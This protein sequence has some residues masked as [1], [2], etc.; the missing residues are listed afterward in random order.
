MKSY[1]PVFLAIV[2]L[3]SI[4]IIIPVSA[5][6]DFEGIPFN[7]AA[8][9]EVNGDIFTFGNYGL[10]NPPYQLS[11]E[12]PANPRYARVYTGIWGGTEKY[13]G[14]ADLRIN[15]LKKITYTLYGE[16]DQNRDVYASGHGIYW[17]AYDATDLLKKGNNVI[18]V[19][20]SKGEPGNKLD[21]R[22]YCIFVV[23]AVEG[24]DNEVTRYWIAE[25][26]E[27]LH[28]EGWAGTNP[29]KHEEANVTFTGAAVSGIS[30]ANLSVLL[31]AGGKGQ[32]DYVEFNGK[33][34]GVPAKVVNGISVTDIGDEKSFDATGGTG[35]DSRY[36][37][38]ETFEVKDLVQESDTVRF[39]RGKDLNG[40]GILATTGDEPEAEDYIHP[41]VAILAI[42]QPG[43]SQ[44]PDLAAGNIRVEN[45]YE[46]ETA[47]LT[48]EIR[49]Y[50]SEQ[51]GPATVVFSIDG[52]TLNTTSVILPGSGVADVSVPWPAIGGTVTL[53]TEVTATGDV[54]TGN[55]LVSR[56]I[57]IGSPPDLTL[58]MGAPV[59]NAD[60]TGVSP[61]QAPL[62]FL[63]AVAGFAALVLFRRRG[64]G[65]AALAVM[66]PLTLM[67]GV[68]VIVVPAGAVSDMQEYT[69]PLEI[70]NSGGSDAP[71]F[72]VTVYLDGE[73]IAEKR[74][75]E[76]LKAHGSLSTGIPVFTSPG[77]HTLKITVDEAGLIKDQNRANNQI[78]GTYDFPR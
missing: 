45:G 7:V 46:G 22:V 77:S 66:L 50:G 57:T 73:K 19:N 36:V 35:F 32:P 67:L 76:G 34:M 10:A 68:A 6:Y 17:I 33:T 74:I 54:V 49:N 71:P 44:G 65:S 42:T 26:N 58:S 23:A 5:L 8:Q 14:W 64:P 18:T 30:R 72:S 75:D 12:L 52:K 24:S 41:V 39:L 37:D 11:F 60:S 78:Q 40:D 27:N 3:I 15:N 31:L 13:T 43:A 51:T 29:T 56:Q 25:G 38:A 59:R 47:L 20:T 21:G 69:L 1:T 2:V 55:N 63:P 4:V 53:S 61:T 9:G 16:R 48:A 70:T 62:S 28:G